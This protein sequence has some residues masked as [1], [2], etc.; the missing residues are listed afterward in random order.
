MKWFNEPDIW[1]ANNNTFEINANPQTD[2]WRITNDNGVRDN[3]HFYYETVSGNFESLVKIVGNY[4]YLYDQAGLMV[5]SDEKNWL[6]CG[7]ELVEDYQN[8]ST[9]VTRD[10]SDWSK[11]AIKNKPDAVWLKMVR[12]YNNISVYFSLSGKSFELFRQAYLEMPG[13]IMVGI[14]CAAP[15]G[16]GFKTTFEEFTIKQKNFVV[17]P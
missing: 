17:F 2:F 7:I 4:K 16:I 5:R 1:S 12:N 8:I 13:E 15:K 10:Q 11:I 3:G 14:M 6:K 9:V